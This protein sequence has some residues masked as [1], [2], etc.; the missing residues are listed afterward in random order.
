MSNE[1]DSHLVVTLDPLSLGYSCY[2]F[3]ETGIA[4][5]TSKT[6]THHADASFRS[7]ILL[8][9]AGRLIPFPCALTWN[10]D[11]VESLTHLN[12]IGLLTGPSSVLEAVM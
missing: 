6:L 12:A 1:P 7:K 2:L 5:G 11:I 8:Q 3:C 4:V 9:T 10:R